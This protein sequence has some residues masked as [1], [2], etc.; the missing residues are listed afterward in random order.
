MD[1]HVREYVIAFQVDGSAPK[2]VQ[3]FDQAGLLRWLAKKLA[4]GFAI[5]TCYEAGPLG[6]VLHCKLTELG[7]TNYVIRPR[8]WDDHAKRVKTDRTDARALLSA[9]DRFLAGNPQALTVVH[10]PG[11]EQERRRSQSRVREEPATATQSRCPA[12][13]RLG[14][15]IWP[16]A[17]SPLVWPTPLAAAGTARLAAGTAGTA[18]ASRAVSQPASRT[19]IQNGQVGQHWPHPLRHGA[20][21]RTNP[22]TGGRGLEPL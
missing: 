12:R 19:T 17:Q 1:V 14:A 16:S 21:D 15:A 5:V 11:I 10:V 3:R 2:P 20:L 22:G 4:E 6:Y 8:N 7:I 18:T 13:T 9:L